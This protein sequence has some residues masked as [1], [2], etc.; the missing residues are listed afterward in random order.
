M[1]WYAWIT[2]DSGIV[3]SVVQLSEHGHTLVNHTLDLCLGRRIAF[4]VTN[5]DI[6]IESF[7]FFCD[8]RKTLKVD[9]SEDEASTTFA[10]E[11]MSYCTTNA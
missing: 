11:G 5:L 2:G 8:R 9:V 3:D 7:E 4:H 6:C 1:S 10:Y